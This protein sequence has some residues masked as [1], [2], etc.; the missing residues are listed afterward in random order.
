MHDHAALPTPH[1]HDLGLAHDL[2]QLQQ[3]MHSRRAGLGLAAALGARSL[4]GLGGVM[5]AG[6]GSGVGGGS[7]QAAT[8]A[9]DCRPY[10]A[11]TAGPFPGNGSN[12]A[13]GSLAN[14]L[15]LSGVVRSDIRASI[16]GASGLAAGVPMRLQMRLVNARGGC[17]DV[18]GCAVYLWQN[19]RDGLYSMYSPGVEGQNY[20]RGVQ[21][22]GA[23][24]VAQFTTVFPGCYPGRMP[25]LHFEVYR[26]IDA[27]TAMNAARAQRLKTAQ[28]AF[29][30][31]TS[32]EVYARAAGYAASAAILKRLSF[33]RDFVFRDGVELQ[34][35]RL[36]ASAVAGSGGGTTEGLAAAIT[37]AVEL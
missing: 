11:S 6:M 32:A 28:I 33:A 5:A 34:M 4:L 14:V 36:S 25:H 16:A 2:V 9:A 26:S 31:D 29:P 22:T 30:V 1:A 12:H 35:A 24:G 15:A 8:S 7:A 3:G 23:D 19:D 21:A 10:P 17:A 37:V 20:L 18:A 27:A 13:N